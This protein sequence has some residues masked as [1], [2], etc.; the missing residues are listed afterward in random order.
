MNAEV[1]IVAKAFSQKSMLKMRG[2]PN[3]NVYWQ[4]INVQKW[5]QCHNQ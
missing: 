1:C 4:A 3:F 2:K 5:E